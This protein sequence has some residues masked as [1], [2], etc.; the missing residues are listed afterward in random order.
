MYV[1]YRRINGNT[2]NRVVI[3]VE[4]DKIFTVWVQYTVVI[5][6]AILWKLL[7]NDLWTVIWRVLRA[8][9]RLTKKS[10]S[11][12]SGGLMIRVLDSKSGCFG[13]NSTSRHCIEQSFISNFK[14]VFESL[15]LNCRMTNKPF[16]R[17]RRNG[18]L[19]NRPKYFHIFSINQ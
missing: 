19:N 12:A 8:S 9:C 18:V 11:T 5:T 2:S 13:F 15:H 6:T 14:L 10:F 16:S 3:L 1:P 4:P 7:M 17:S